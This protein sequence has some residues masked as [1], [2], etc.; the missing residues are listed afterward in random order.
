[1]TC[2]FVVV[3][4]GGGGGTIAWLLGKAGFSVVLLDQGVDWSAGLD[5]DW[6]DGNDL[7]ARRYD[8][9]SHDEYRFRIA[10]PEVKR[11]LRGDYNTFRSNTSYEAMPS[12]G[13]WTGSQLGGGSVLWGS[14]GFRALPIDFVL[15]THFEARGQAQR[16]R[17]CGYAL[18]PRSVLSRSE[19]K[20]AGDKAGVGVLLVESFVSDRFGQEKLNAK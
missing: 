15:A 17:E 16:L 7:N 19:A 14:W 1:V 11:R 5:A 8:P 20:P 13:G 10:R 3:G 4:S 9:A 12:S 6:S 18:G 2:D